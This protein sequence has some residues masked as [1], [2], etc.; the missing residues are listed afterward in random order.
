MT[1]I[2]DDYKTTITTKEIELE[3]LITD[4]LISKTDRKEKYE[5]IQQLLIQQNE[6]EANI[7]ILKKEKGKDEHRQMITVLYRF[8]F[9]S[10]GK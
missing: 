10:S 6:C 2:V 8:P 7:V 3:K 5:A 9:S 1:K 4:K